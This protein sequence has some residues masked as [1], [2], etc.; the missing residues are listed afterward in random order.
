MVHCGSD[1]IE[2]IPTPGT[3]LEYMQGLIYPRSGSYKVRP[4]YEY[5][6]VL[7][8]GR[9]V[10]SDVEQIPENPGSN[11][12]V[13]VIC[14]ITDDGEIVRADFLYRLNLGS[15]ANAPM[16][17][18]GN[19]RYYFVFPPMPDGYRIDCAIE[20][21]DDEG[22]VAHWPE[23]YPWNFHI[24]YVYDQSAIN[25]NLMLPLKA[26]LYQNYPNPFNAST[27]INFTLPEASLVTL[28][29]Y[30]L[31][32]REAAILAEKWLPAGIHSVKFAGPDLPSGIYFYQLR[33]SGFTQTKRMNLVK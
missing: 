19:D 26:T 8:D 15:W 23:D 31:L 2:Y 25:N 4:R 20:A 30:D 29:V 11:D 18:A 32:G 5:D 1:S 28:K 3:E 16:V 9:P 14:T 33:T 6:I 27:S 22:N 17:Y 24:I 13:T 21:E 12:S 7:P 10:I